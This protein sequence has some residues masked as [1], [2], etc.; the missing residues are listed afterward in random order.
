M[1]MNKSTL[2]AIFEAQIIPLLVAKP[3]TQYRFHPTRQWRFDYAFPWKRLAVEIDGGQWQAHGGRHN[4][5]ADREKL[6]EAAKLGWR[7]LRYSGT[8][9]KKPYDIAEQIYDALEAQT[10][11]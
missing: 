9:L 10:A 7:V 5:D 2:E 11:I 1:T 8:M 4:T 3:V 6:N